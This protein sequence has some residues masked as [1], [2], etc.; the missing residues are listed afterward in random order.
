MIDITGIQKRNRNRQ[1]P[2]VHVSQGLNEVGGF[3]RFYIGANISM[4]TFKD[5]EPQRITKFF[6]GLTQVVHARGNPSD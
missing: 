6:E 3:T 4:D 1:L 2:A 5:W